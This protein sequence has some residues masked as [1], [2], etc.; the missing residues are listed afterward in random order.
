MKQSA[1]AVFVSIVG[2]LNVASSPAQTPTPRATPTSF[3]VFSVKPNLTGSEA[4]RAGSSPGGLFTVRNVSLQLLISR[5]FG[6]AEF[7]VE[8]GPGRVDSEK[9]DI[10]A[11]ADTPL[12]MS[13]E[14]LR[15]CLQALLA[16]RFRLKFHRET[17]E[18]SVYSLVVGKNGSKL[19]ERSGGGTPAIGVSSGVGK[20][21]LTGT[22][23]MM[24][25]LAEYLSGQAGRPVVDNTLLKGEYDF[26]VGWATEETVGSSEPSLF[27]ALQEQLGLKLD[28][29]RGPV[30]MGHFEPA[31]AS[32]S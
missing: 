8:R 6:A 1:R 19:Q 13:R 20:A 9:Y 21:D 17:K 16:E 12:E 26:K 10:T 3:D 23:V 31:T 18:G 28:A 11:K 15:P 5:E 29:T 7:Q 30:D 24:A 2:A 4:R 14:E 22:K 32:A 27:T 25:R